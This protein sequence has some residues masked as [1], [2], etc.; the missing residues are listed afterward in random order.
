MNKIKYVHRYE[1]DAH[2][3]PLWSSESKESM[4][5]TES[6]ES[7]ANS[8]NIRLIRPITLSV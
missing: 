4:E 6:M 2:A 3:P 7:I 8:K 1:M 5:S